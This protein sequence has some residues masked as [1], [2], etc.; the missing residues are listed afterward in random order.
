MGDGLLPADFDGTK[1]PKDDAAIPV[2]GTQD[3]GAGYGGTFDAL[4]VWDLR[5][6]WNSTPQAS[7]V[8]ATQLPTAPFD[9]VFPCAPTSRDCI[10]QPGITDPTRYL[11][12]L[13]YRQRPTWR[14][15]YR[16]FSTYESLV[17]NQSVEAT[18]RRRRRPLVRDPAHRHG[19]YSHLSS[20]APTRRATACT[21]GWAASPRTRTATWRSATASST[22]STF[23]P[24]SAT[25]AGSPA[26][27]SDR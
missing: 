20:R 27:R 16:N 21:G 13:S 12:I 4:N 24:G 5:I 14:L 2:V 17:T 18:A 22:A 10:P 7:L 25:R 9:S 19:A 6:K 8:L 15:A 3:D 11:D 26:T 23:F 1:Q